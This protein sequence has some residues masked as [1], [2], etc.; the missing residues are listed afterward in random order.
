VYGMER[1][2]VEGEIVEAYERLVAAFG[3]QR[4]DDYFGCFADEATLAFNGVRWLGSL[5]SIETRQRSRAGEETLHERETIVFAKQPDGRWLVVHE[6]L[7][8]SPVLDECRGDTP[9]LSQEGST[10]A[11]PACWNLPTGSRSEVPEPPAR[12]AART[13]RRGQPSCLQ[14]LSLLNADAREPLAL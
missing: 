11:R 4:L 2:A 12:R 9:S 3:E 8:P 7:S 13:G 14:A 5:H 6:H 1:R 10:N